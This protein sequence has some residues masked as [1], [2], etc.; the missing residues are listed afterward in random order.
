MIEER[1]RRSGKSASDTGHTERQPRGVAEGH[2]ERGPENPSASR[3]AVASAG[4]QGLPPRRRRRWLSAEKKFQLFL[5]CAIPGAPIGEIL[6]R[7][8]LYSS[9]LA[10][11]RAHV[12][13]GAL[14][15]LQQGPGRKKPPLP[16][17]EI[18]HLVRE[19]GEKERALAALSVE[20][21][22]LKKDASRASRGR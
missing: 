11:I 20:Y 19:L 22:A 8:G 1:R 7:E 17:E 16:A 15:R 9:D 12:K 2:G 6:R 3:A 4:E 13:E 5:E 18:E 10:R 21:L 14:E